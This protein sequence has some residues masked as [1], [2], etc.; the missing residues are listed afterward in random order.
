MAPT[1]DATVGSIDVPF[2]GLGSSI[3]IT[4][5][6]FTPPSEVQIGGVSQTYTFVSDT[7]IRIDV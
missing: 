1:S 2:V 4:V 7:E 6:G 3:T 5:T